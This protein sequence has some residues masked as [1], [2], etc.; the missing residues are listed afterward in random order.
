MK[1][2]AEGHQNEGTS[3]FCGECGQ[4]LPIE[5][6]IPETREFE[7]DASEEASV[8]Q[9]PQDFGGVDGAGVTSKSGSNR[10]R[11]T[12]LASVVLVTVGVAVLIMSLTGSSSK[13]GPSEQDFRGFSNAALSF[14]F[15]PEEVSQGSYVTTEIS[16]IDPRWGLVSWPLNTPGSEGVDYYMWI[17]R[18]SGKYYGMN[19]PNE[20]GAT[21][22]MTYMPA[23]SGPNC[24][25]Q[26]DFNVCEG[27]WWTKQVRI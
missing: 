17:D 27:T 25:Q 18:A 3:R 21:E 22:I 11:L 26:M 5:E 1:R 8:V 16:K 2:C 19:A 12:I 20:Y 23:S 9:A 7:A 24:P 6:S 4:P 14:A 15:G 13:S 10:M